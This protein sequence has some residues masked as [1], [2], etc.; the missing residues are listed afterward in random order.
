MLTGR[1]GA[2][3]TASRYLKRESY[4]AC[5]EH[6]MSDTREIYPFLLSQIQN[7]ESYFAAP[8]DHW[9]QGRDSFPC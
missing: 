8:S 2:E 9:I 7:I 6:K 3:D 5:H 4:M 1:L